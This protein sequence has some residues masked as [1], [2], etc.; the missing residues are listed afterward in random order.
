MDIDDKIMF[1]D[2]VLLPVYGFKSVDDYTFELSQD[3]IDDNMLDKLNHILDQLYTVFQKNFID[4]HKTENHLQSAKQAYN[5]LQKCLTETQIM[6]STRIVRVK[7]KHLNYLRLNQKNLNLEN[8]IQR[9][10]S[11]FQTKQNITINA[12]QIT[13]PDSQEQLTY[14]KPVPVSADVRSNIPI[15]SA[16]ELF[17]KIKYRRIIKRRLCAPLNHILQLINYNRLDYCVEQISI[18]YINRT[19]NIIDSKTFGVDL[20]IE[21]IAHHMIH[22]ESYQPKEPLLPPKVVIPLSWFGAVNLQVTSPL[23]EQETHD[24]CIEMITTNKFSKM[25]SSFNKGTLLYQWQTMIY[26]HNYGKMDVSQTITGSLRDILIRIHQQDHVDES[27]HVDEYHQKIPVNWGQLDK[28][29]LKVVEEG[30]RRLLLPTEYLCGLQGLSQIIPYKELKYD[31]IIAQYR[32]IVRP[33]EMSEFPDCCIV[34]YCVDWYPSFKT[35]RMTL[36]F[37]L[38]IDNELIFEFCNGYDSKI[39]TFA[40]ISPHRYKDLYGSEPQLYGT[41]Y[42]FQNL[43]KELPSPKMNNYLRIK[44]SREIYQKLEGNFNCQVTRVP[45]YDEGSP[46]FY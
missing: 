12:S 6:Y 29:E 38:V 28:I 14:Q 4:L 1:I 17:S 8:Y 31:G 41:L 35:L 27:H 26:H 5:L 42:H 21:Q 44:M 45:I 46:P 39:L 40:K 13:I 24:L 43:E 34:E 10:M 22:N 2:T 9:K 7:N 19:D 37:S 25:C 32:N 18:Y 16:H 36:G 3:Q 30:S 20:S 15:I 33:C 11:E 23:N